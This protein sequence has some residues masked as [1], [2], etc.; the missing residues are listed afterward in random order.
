MYYK[1]KYNNDNEKQT[2]KTERDWL[3]ECAKHL[4]RMNACVTI[5][6]YRLVAKCD[7]CQNLPTSRLIICFREILFSTNT[8]VYLPLHGHQLWLHFVIKF[9]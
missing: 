7:F 5:Y 1:N 8:T 3:M 2:L 6:M 9:E 4:I